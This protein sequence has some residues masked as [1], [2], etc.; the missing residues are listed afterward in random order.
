MP[1][2]DW[3]TYRTTTAPGGGHHT[4]SMVDLR[5]RKA[6]PPIDLGVLR[7]AH[8]LA[9]AHGKVWFTAETN[10]V[11]GSYD[12]ANKQVDWVLGTGQNRTHMIAVSEDLKR[13]ITS[14]VGSA[15]M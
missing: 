6:L 8:G 4:I 2:E 5:E 1:M 14:N 9:F 11:I 13:I 3:P 12:P 10:K 7:G 15:T